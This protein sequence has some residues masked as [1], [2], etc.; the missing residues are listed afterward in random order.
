MLAV[1]VLAGQGHSVSNFQFHFFMC[2]WFNLFVRDILI[3]ECYLT[4]YF[5][6]NL[7]NLCIC[8]SE[9]KGCRD[10]YILCFY[11]SIYSCKPQFIL[12]AF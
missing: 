3:C 1:H 6:F 7:Y 11:H 8:F 12:I 9:K 4:K 2:D 10:S 5:I